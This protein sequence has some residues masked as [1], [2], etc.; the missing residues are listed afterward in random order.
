MKIS[1]TK[2][3]KTLIIY[4]VRIVLMPIQPNQK[5]LS[6][7]TNHPPT[8]NILP[9]EMTCSYLNTMYIMDFNMQRIITNKV[10]ENSILGPK[11]KNTLITTSTLNIKR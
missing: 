8:Q 4:K 11:H 7:Q 6:V 10:I 3:K 5:Y 1:H 9:Y 2:K